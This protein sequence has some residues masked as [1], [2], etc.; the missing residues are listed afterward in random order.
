MAKMSKARIRQLAQGVDVDLNIIEDLSGFENLI[1]ACKKAHNRQIRFGWLE[2]K[3]YPADKNK[4]SL[5]V[6]QVAF[7]QEFGT[8]RFV[9]RPYFRQLINQVKYRFNGDIKNFM[10]DVV[11]GV[12]SEQKL[13]NLA[14]E[15][16]YSY[17]S[18]VSRQQ[19]KKLSPITI[20][21]KGHDFQLDNTGVMLNS[22]KAK[23]FHQN[24][25]NIKQHD[26][27]IDDY[28]SYW[29]AVKSRRAS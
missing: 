8:E 4:P 28:K 10:T 27:K 3:K 6:A 16:E 24:I 12:V 7:W 25:E 19:Y 29:Q 23:V 9:A 15:I 13:L 20:R 1:K 5:Y 26:V 22:F 17:H 18:T 14:N 21:I 2:K 11:H